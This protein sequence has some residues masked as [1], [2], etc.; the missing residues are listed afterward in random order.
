MQQEEGLS[1]VN[2]HSE[3]VAKLPKHVLVGTST[4]PLSSSVQPLE[5][6][7]IPTAQTFCWNM[8]QQ[9]RGKNCQGLLVSFQPDSNPVVSLEFNPFISCCPQFPS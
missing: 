3:L 2:G 5:V 4:F 1:S 6:V 7:I 9:L 8:L